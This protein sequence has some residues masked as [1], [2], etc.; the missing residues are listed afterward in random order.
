MSTY[1]YFFFLVLRSLQSLR[2]N[3]PLLVINVKT[4]VPFVRNE[5]KGIV[6]YILD[7]FLWI[8][9]QQNNWL[10]VV[11]RNHSFSNWISVKF[12]GKYNINRNLILKDVTNW[13]NLFDSFV[14]QVSYWLSMII[15][16]HCLGEN[17][18]IYDICLI[19][20]HFI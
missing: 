19:H 10:G 1:P 17:H 7:R 5:C 13:I 18:G 12:T 6:S 20:P 4:K 2:L 14:Y 9:F 15:I 16:C 8:V 11:M 3:N